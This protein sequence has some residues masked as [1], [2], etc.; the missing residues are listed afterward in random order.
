MKVSLS[1]K[2]LVPKLVT[3]L[4]EGY[5]FNT[6]KKDFIAGLTAGILAFPLA[7]A[8]AIGIGVSPLQGL[9]ASIIGGFLAS[10]L[11]GS[12]VLISGPT[13]SFI[14]ILYC[15]G[16]KYG[17]DGLF[18]ITLMAGIFLIIFGLAGL[19]TFIKY[20]PYPVVTGLTTGIAVIIFSSQ[21]RDFLGLQMGDGVPLDFIG[22]WV[23][24]WDYL[25][26]WD[27]KTFAVGLFT[28]LLMIYFRNYKPRY[29]GVMISIIIAST[30]VW[31]L[32]ID[33]P[34]IGSRYGTLPSSLPGPVFPHISI[35][36]ML[37]LMPDALTIAVLSGIETLLAAVVA[38][39]MTG[40]RHQSNCQLIGQGI[41]NIG[42]S[43]F[44]G[45]PVTGSLSRTTASIKCGASTP[46][47]GIIHAICLTFILL[48]LAPLTI[49]IPLTC[50]AAVLILIAWNMSEI[51]HFI[52][53]FTAPKED[54]LVLLTVF[55]LTVMTTITSAV[56]VGMM[57]AAF[58]FMK[59]MSD[60]SDVISTAQYFD[61]SE[62]PQNDLLFSKNEVPPFTEIYEINGPFFFGIADRL[63]NLLNEIE[64]PPRIFILCMTR[65]PTIDASAMHALE[66]FFLECD[67]QGTLLLLAGV[68]K[69]PLNDLRRYHVDELIGVDHIFSNIKGALLFAKALIKLESKSSQ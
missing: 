48:L 3:C 33:I 31:I 27:S 69:T 25:W 55:I 29:P 28:L 12:R 54:I 5:S 40:W 17:E 47:A 46:I 13:S 68:K 58:L 57:L 53:L 6:L 24:Y 59:R 15:I 51:H 39:G 26:T 49:K 45:M 35:T 32:K 30:L 9:L 8:I 42:T 36:K 64:K 52:H 7:I 2:H 11:G 19:G 61:E 10:A 16:V 21:I 43:L 38:D 65:V 18:T 22:K 66:E 62:Q 60:L 37:Q 56:Q 67:R 20:M 41:A 63:K 1:F 4:K 23:A 14:S 50:L 34:T 44:A